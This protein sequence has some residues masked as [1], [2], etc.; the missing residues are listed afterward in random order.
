M[1]FDV[2]G[3]GAAAYDYLCIIDNYPQEDG[4]ANILE[5]HNQGGGCVATALVATQRLGFSTAYIGNT[6]DNFGG[7]YIR[8]DFVREGVD[9]SLVEVI[10]GR[11][12]TEGYVLIDPVRSTR[13]K[14]PYS[15]NLPGISWTKEKEDMIRNARILHIDGTN[16]A[17]CLHA[18]QIARQAGVPVSLDGCAR[19][20]DTR[21]NANLA[22]LADILIMNEEFPYYASGKDDLE[23]A[24]RFFAG[25]E[26][27]IVISTLGARGS[28]ALINGQLVSFPAYKVEAIDTTGAGDVFHGAFVAGWL[29]GY[30]LPQCIRYASAV[31]AMKCR[32]IGGR[33]G[34]PKHDEGLDFMKEHAEDL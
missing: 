20:K 10:E 13:T 23:E 2:V 25:D 17:N 9:I 30:E 32:Q 19:K 16:Y 31:A 24:M 3:V 34:I 18:A 21:L 6:G 26:N 1:K 14:F 5:I 29:R 27:K 33:A 8:D 11:H 28:V 15:N 7:Q 12:S 22:M 4:S